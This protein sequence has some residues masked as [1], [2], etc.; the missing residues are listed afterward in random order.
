MTQS[1]GGSSGSSGGKGGGG[2]AE[3]VALKKGPWTA[4]EDQILIDYVYNHGEGNWNSS[5]E[6]FWPQLLQEKLPSLMG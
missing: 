4:A 3:G 1:D 5:V 6:I 2:V